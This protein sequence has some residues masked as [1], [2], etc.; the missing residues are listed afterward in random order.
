MIIIFLL[1]VKMVIWV[2]YRSFHENEED[3]VEAIKE[4][5]NND[6]ILNKEVIAVAQGNELTVTGLNPE[7]DFSNI[8]WNIEGELAPQTVTFNGVAQP[9]SEQ[10]FE[11]EELGWGRTSSKSSIQFIAGPGSE[12][13]IPFSI[14]F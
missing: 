13:S 5:I 4:A 6:D 3:T 9:S 12:E 11:N 14:S 1:K 10:T 8:R 2:Q 7:S